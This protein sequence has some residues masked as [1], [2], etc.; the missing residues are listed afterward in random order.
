MRNRDRARLAA[1]GIA[2]VAADRDPLAG[3]VAGAP[4][5]CLNSGTLTRGAEIVD[6]H[7]IL[8]RDGPRIWRTGPRGDC[9]SLRPYATLIVELWGGTICRG[10]RFRTVDSGLRIPSGSCQFDVFTPYTKAQ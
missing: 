8:Y 2:L 6:A 5:T 9:P 4:Q 3:R 1:L 7:T 10:D